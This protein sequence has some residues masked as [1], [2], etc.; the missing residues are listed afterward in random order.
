MAVGGCFPP[1]LTLEAVRRRHRNQS[2]RQKMSCT[3]EL[4]PLDMMPSSQRKSIR[5]RCKYMWFVVVNYNYFFPAD[6]LVTTKN[7][8]RS[9]V[10]GSLELPAPPTSK[11]YICVGCSSS[12]RIRV[13][14]SF[15]ILQLVFCPLD[16]VPFGRNQRAKFVRA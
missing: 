5:S 12:T 2:V 7:I 10:P 6:Y 16:T 13:I 9:A 15:A 1:V 8:K 3:P 14:S 4:R 11:M